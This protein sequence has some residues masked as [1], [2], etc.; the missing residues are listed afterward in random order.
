MF[1]ISRIA[2][3]WRFHNYLFV[4]TYYPLVLQLT[5]VSFHW[6]FCWFSFHFLFLLSLEGYLKFLLFYSYIEIVIFGCIF[7][8]FKT[9]S[10]C[11][12]G[13][14]SLF[15]NYTVLLCMQLL[16]KGRNFSTLD[17]STNESI[18]FC[19]LILLVETYASLKKWSAVLIILN[20]FG[21]SL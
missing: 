6:C 13:F 17:L 8:Y 5:S 15:M 3:Y 14:C 20:I 7:I 9:F 2:I 21:I 11:W 18:Y 19:V 10:C 4:L 16:F 1:Y 12:C